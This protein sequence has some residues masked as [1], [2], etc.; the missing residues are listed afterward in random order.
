VRPR[1]W[2]GPI[3]LPRIRAETGAWA[4]AA[5][6]RRKRGS[7]NSVAVAVA[8]VGRTQSRGQ[9]AA[10]GARSAGR[11][12]P[13]RCARSAARTCRRAGRRTRGLGG[14]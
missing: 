1:R 4:T 14:R 8:A 6:T 10:R 5:G 2:L 3:I 12:G 9:P 11:P 7:C 13:G